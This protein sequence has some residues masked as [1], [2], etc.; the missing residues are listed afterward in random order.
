MWPCRM[1][2]PV[3]AA[4]K[5]ST[6]T[7][8]ARRLSACVLTP[9]VTHLSQTE[10]CEAAPGLDFLSMSFSS[11][12]QTRC[13][14]GREK[15]PRRAPTVQLGLSRSEDHLMLRRSVQPSTRVAGTRNRV[16]QPP[17][18][19][20][21]PKSASGGRMWRRIG[22]LPD[23]AQ[24]MLLTRDVFIA[25][26]RR[27]CLPPMGYLGPPGDRYSSCGMLAIHKATVASP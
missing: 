27:Q 16:V 11:S 7:N 12:T 1:Y 8:Q 4:T 25:K 17:S 22:W 21:E 20:A 18:Q 5:V 10:M 9:Y 14:S 19:L 13:R 2:T 24:S 6:L 23:S 26:I 3:I 15:H